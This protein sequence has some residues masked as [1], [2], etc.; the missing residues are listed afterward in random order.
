MSELSVKSKENRDLPLNKSVILLL[1]SLLLSTLFNILFYDKTPGISY[2][3]YALTFYVL[4]FINF[5]NTDINITKSGLNNIN[6]IFIL[7]LSLTYTLFTNDVFMVLNILSIPLLVVAHTLILTNKSKNKWFK[8]SFLSDMV[9]GIFYGAFAFFFKPISMLGKYLKI[10]T[11]KSKYTNLKKISL[12]LLISVPL[13]FIIIPLLSSADSAFNNI[14][15][16]FFELFA[17]IDISEI[18]F[19]I[20]LFVIVFGLTFSYMYFL[21][22]PNENKEVNIEKSNKPNQAFDPITVIT[23]LISINIV[24]VIFAFLQFSYLFSLPKNLSYS[25]Y[26]RK[27]FFELVLVTLINLTILLLT[28]HLTK[29][30][31]AKTAI[32]LKI[33]NILLIFC[34]I[35]MLISAFFRM[36]LYEQVYG[37]TYLRVFTHSFMLYIF[38]LLMAT[39]YKIFA[40]KVHILKLYIIISLVAYTLINYANVDVFIAKNNIARFHNDSKQLDINYLTNLSYE[41]VPE[42]LEFLPELKEKAPQTAAI[43]ENDLYIKKNNLKDFNAWQSFN[44]SINRAKEAL[45]KYDLKY[46]ATA[47]KNRYIPD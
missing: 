33:L 28:I 42:L 35:V 17:S 23:V 7:L 18:K 14:F 47:E 10:S 32:S 38:A 22:L 19:R 8:F 15:K 2:L 9:Y 12:G 45:A 24:Y 5:K 37:F 3:I 31:T 27:G 34:T 16:D 26:A 13:L 44:F 6:L 4:F 20:I 36:Y 40:D 21:T 25:E 29:K 41:A 30:N 39:L 43:L 11:D 1:I 46:D